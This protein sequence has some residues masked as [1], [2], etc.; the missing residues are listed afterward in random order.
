MSRRVEQPRLA[1][2][3]REGLLA[4]S[5]VGRQGYP[6]IPTLIRCIFVKSMQPQPTLSTNFV[7]TPTRWQIAPSIA[8]FSACCWALGLGAHGYPGGYLYRKPLVRKSRTSNL[9]AQSWPFDALQV[10][11]PIPHSLLQWWITILCI[12]RPHQTQKC[13]AEKGVG[14]DG[15]DAARPARPN[16]TCMY[17]YCMYCAPR[18]R[19]PR[20]D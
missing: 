12:G 13:R 5:G 3:S 8:Q 6:T 14:S 16:S 20:N 4:R 17:V 10:L 7:P 18:T 9:F 19:R 11:C 15:K 2:A 1:G